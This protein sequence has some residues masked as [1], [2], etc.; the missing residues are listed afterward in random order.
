M[1]PAVSPDDPQLRT[2]F[3]VYKFANGISMLLWFGAVVSLIIYRSL[4]ISTQLALAGG[5]WIFLPD[6][7]TVKLL[8][9][10]FDAYRRHKIESMDSDSI[11][12]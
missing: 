7:K 8:F 2:E 6:T 10:G 5:V 12:T 11:D 1:K 9:S 4:P 3:I